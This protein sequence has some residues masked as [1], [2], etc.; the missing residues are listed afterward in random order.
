MIPVITLLVGENSFEV[1]RNVQRTCA[2]FD[3]VA[4]KIDGTQLQLAQLS[5][6]LMGTTLFADKRLVIIKNVSENKAIWTVLDEWI[7]RISDDV[8]LV[9]VEPKPDKRTKTYKAVSKKAEVYEANIWTERD[10]PKAET[11]ASEEAK[12][13]GFSLDKKSAHTLVERVGVDQWAL[14]WALEKLAVLGDITPKVIEEHIEAS[15]TESVFG[16]FEAALKGEVSTLK[17]MLA[18]LEM[19]EDA[20]RLF[21]LLAGQAFQLAVLSVADTSPTEVAKAIGVHP[22]ALGKLAPFVKGRSARQV[23]QIVEVFADADIAMKTSVADP[24]LLIERALIKVAT[25]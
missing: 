22:F 16:V 25:Q 7:D 12:E 5:D 21:G 8:H 14:Y 15:P 1:E 4:E 23:G 17:Q 6:V 10:S 18:T 20:Y 19:S 13:L 11:W 24:W 2:V 9:L 3:G